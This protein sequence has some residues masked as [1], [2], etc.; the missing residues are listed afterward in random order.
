MPTN[1][2]ENKVRVTRLFGGGGV[3]GLMDPK[4]NMQV[5]YGQSPYWVKALDAG[6]FQAQLALAS[7]GAVKQKAYPHDLQVD[8]TVASGFGWPASA[9]SVL[10]GHNGVF[11]N[12][13]PSVPGTGV[14]YLGG[15]GTVHTFGRA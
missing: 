15:D 12:G 8:V 11:A 7:G 6:N 3:L 13:V 4:V 1:K 5:K 14:S 9:D 10:F 2:S